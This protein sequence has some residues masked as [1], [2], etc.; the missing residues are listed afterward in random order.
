MGRPRPSRKGDLI[1][2]HSST[3]RVG[4]LDFQLVEEPRK[5]GVGAQEWLEG[6]SALR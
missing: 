3:H 1:E 2:Y 6:R 5:L 4:N